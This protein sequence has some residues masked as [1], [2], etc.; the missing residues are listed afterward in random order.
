LNSSVNPGVAARIIDGRYALTN[1]PIRHGG[2]STVSKAVDLQTSRFCAIKRVKGGNQDDLRLK[3]SF[4]REYAALNELCQH[5]NI[6]ELLDAGADEAGFYM[7]LE[8][9][10]ANLVDLITQR[11]ALEWREFYTAIGRPILDALVYAQN[12]GWNHR[13][14]KPQNVL[15]DDNGV[16]K[17]SDYGIAKQFE[18]PSLGLTFAQFRS[19]PFTPPEDDGGEWSCSRDCFSWAAVAVYCLSGKMPADYGELSELLGSLDQ[20][21]VPSSLL[22]LA[23]SHVPSERPP[24]ASS[25]LADLDA[26]AAKS[27]AKSRPAFTFYIRLEGECTLRILRQIDRSDPKDAERFVLDE[28]HEVEVGLKYIPA[29]EGADELLRI[30]A[31]TWT[32]EARRFSKNSERWSIRRA[33]QGGAGNVEREREL[34]FRALVMFSFGNPADVLEATEEL[35]ELVLQIEAFEQERRDRAIAQQRERVFRLWY[36]F[37]RNKADY[38]ESR[39][40][41]IVYID[42]KRTDNAVTLST[43]LPVGLELIGQSRVIK[44]V[45]GGHVFCD[46]VDINLQEVVVTV[47]FGDS[48]LIPRQG[49]LEV[50]TIAAEKAI[51]RQRRALDSINYDR[52]AS[53]R[54]K[55]VL[56]QPSAARPP[57]ALTVPPATRA[58]FDPE[59]QEILSRALGLQDILAIQGPPGTGKTTLIEEIIVQYLLRNP[60]HRVLLSS[61]T[62]VALDNVIDRVRAR[63]PAIDI[64]RI[65]RLDDLKVSPSCRDLI[66]D[67][68]AQ[69]WSETVRERAHAF[70]A[71]LAKSKG[72]DRTNIEVG[73]L[74][75]R[76]VL[77]LQQES[78]IKESLSRADDRVRS[79]D[80]QAEKTLME[81]GTSA[82]AGTDAA[83]IE[84]QE[85]A[86]AFRSVLARLRADIEEVRARLTQRDGYG[87]ELSTRS[88]T[89]ELRDWSSMLLGDTDEAKHFRELLKLQEDWLLRVGRSSDFH[90]AMLASAQV[91]AGTC[92]GMASV[93]GMAD[94]VYDLCIVDEAS[95]ATATEILVPMARSRKWI[96]VGDPAQL[97]PFFEN[98]AITRL[99]EFDEAEV[100]Q[101]LLDR[102]LSSLP[103]HSV[104]RLTNQ[105]RMVRPIGN[106]IS[107]VFYGGKLNS[108]K[109]KPDVT[110]PGA[111]PKPVT[112]LSTAETCDF[113]EARRGQSFR[114]EA[115]CRI[116][117]D[118]LQQID[119]LAKKRKASYDVAVI[120]GY[121]AQVKALQDAIRDR[122]HEWS[123]LRI[124]CSTVDAFQ[125]SEAEVCIYSVVRSNREGRLGFLREKPR[126]NVALSRGRSALVIVGDDEFCREAEGENP[127]RKVLDFIDANADSCERRMA[128]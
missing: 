69:V 31:V 71:E 27:A 17:L 19:A 18:R 102:F 127:F 4:N 44:T 13:D 35:R 86:G 14:I 70:I 89:K 91:V 116:I 3:D 92:I 34:C 39:E 118:L 5:P 68:K 2:M 63:Q 32:F 48:N 110:F 82:S 8:W 113:R 119:F 58:S 29:Q 72:I 11:G 45:S 52:A 49:R 57:A 115:E 7:V 20:S 38:E 112:W 128:R 10:P 12:R 54:L 47:T 74:V 100:R 59:K 65:G 73:M 79:V 43:E 56:V 21:S 76:L 105:H 93:R 87:A 46:I 84:A 99:E 40:N 111:L 41:A 107:E 6:V 101:T 96:L 88:E 124:T 61:Q 62:H 121:V 104:A 64:V 16:P 106:L 90:A 26:I 98:E 125:G 36:S 30:T 83:A 60:Q 85:A 120:A 94:V 25:L 122:I 51:E 9:V 97:P 67:R 42:A 117:R 80:A 109:V 95:K 126:L 66:L 114:N 108:P 23:L 1:E 24:L 50:N 75:E 103:E 55:A 53:S 33:W 37:L 22:Q 81:T 77:L 78:S 123:G 15:I 28:L